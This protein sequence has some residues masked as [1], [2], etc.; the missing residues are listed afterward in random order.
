MC[1]LEKLLDFHIDAP[2][3]VF[4][5]LGTLALGSA[6]AAVAFLT[7][8]SGWTKLAGYVFVIS[9]ILAWYVASAMMLAA[10]TGRIILPLFK[11]PREANIPGRSPRRAIELE[12]GEPGVKQGQ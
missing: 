7:G 6:C 1:G 9:A 11:T 12:W 8:G 10:A 4:A 3:G 2:C 5:V